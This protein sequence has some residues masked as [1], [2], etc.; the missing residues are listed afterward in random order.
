MMTNHHFIVCD[1]SSQ[2]CNFTQWQKVIGKLVFQ[3]L[4]EE[5]LACSQ[6]DSISLFWQ[7]EGAMRQTWEYWEIW[8][9]DWQTSQNFSDEAWRGKKCPLLVSDFLLKFN[10]GKWGYFQLFTFHISYWFTNFPLCTYRQTV[11]GNTCVCVMHRLILACPS[12]LSLFDL[13]LS[14]IFLSTA[15][16]FVIGILKS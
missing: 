10:S 11:K 12:S 1:S 7:V 16:C 8:A 4:D 15:G 5:T 2:L 14:H 9:W 13:L 3:Y 6:K